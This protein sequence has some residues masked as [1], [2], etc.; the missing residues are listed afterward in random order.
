MVLFKPVPVSE[1]DIFLISGEINF[2]SVTSLTDYHS[3][4]VILVSGTQKR[5]LFN[6]PDYGTFVICEFGPN[7]D[8]KPQYMYTC[9]SAPMTT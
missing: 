1:T 3:V 2:T 4:N 7:Q 5:K 8:L 9:G 6:F